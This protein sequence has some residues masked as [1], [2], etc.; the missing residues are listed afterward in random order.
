MPG[1][2]RGVRNP[3]LHGDY[4]FQCVLVHGGPGAPGELEPLGQRLASRMGVIESFQT[5]WTIPSLIDELQ[6]NIALFGNQP[7]LSIGHSWGAWLSLL[8]AA[9][10]PKSIRKLVLVGAAPFHQN[11]HEIIKV[12]RINRL[13]LDEQ[14]EILRLRAALN[15]PEN[16]LTEPF[17]KR[18]VEI[19]RKVDHYDPIHMKNPVL[20]I[21]FAMNKTIWKQASAWRDSGKLLH[22]IK[23]ISCP[24]V[25]IHGDYDAHPF[26]SVEE[27]L[28][29]L[30]K[31]FQFYL[32]PQ[33]GHVPWNE[34]KAI[35]DFYK[36]LLK[37]L[38]PQ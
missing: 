16:E 13:S 35:D 25:A 18:Y 5:E 14:E 31:E 6:E 24:V 10:Y 20:E 4:P 15:G 32:I 30:V 21:Q 3:R 33:C 38:M 7:I 1:E 26:Q 36:I 23:K 9:K 22:E 34:K 28:S 17:F 37:E 11:A 12:N 2:V 19:L 29:K 8:H 27:V